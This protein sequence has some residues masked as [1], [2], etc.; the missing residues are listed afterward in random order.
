MSPIGSPS[1]DRHP[2]LSRLTRCSALALGL[3]ETTGVEVQGA[4]DLLRDQ[5]TNTSAA[6]VP[7]RGPVAERA[8]DTAEIKGGKGSVFYRAHSYHTKVPVEGL[9]RLIEH[10]TDPG[11]V[12]VDPFAGSGMT[13][14]AALLTARRAILSDLSP[15]AVH[16]SRGYTT[17]VDP[18]LVSNAAEKIL[19]TLL[20]VENTLYGDPRGRL[21]Y[22]VWSDV[23]VCP[24]CGTDIVFWDAGVDHES[25]QVKRDLACHAGHGPYPKTRLV[26]RRAIPVQENLSTGARKRLVREVG[27]PAR[28]AAKIGRADIPWWYPTTPW[29]S[30]R[31][32]WRGQHRDMAISTAADF[33]T[34]RNL[35]GL[36]ALWNEI[37]QLEEA[38]IRDALRF[39]FTATVNRASRRYQWHPTRPTNVL[40]ST[41]Y[42]ASL[43]YEFNVFSLFRRK[44][45]T[46]IEMFER[47][48]RATGACE[49]REGSATSLDWLPDESVDYVFTDPPFGSNIFYADSSFLWEAWLGKETD[50]SAE[51]VVNKSVSA[52]HGGKSLPDYEALM[53]TA[54]SEIARVLRPNAWASLQFHNSDD[55]VWSSIQR[56]VE[57][58]GF[59][60]EA[61]VIMDKNQASFKGLRHERYGE[62]V[63]NFDL[64]MHLRRSGPC[65]TAVVRAVVSR[66]QLVAELERHLAT[67]P[68]SRRTTPFLHSVAMR[69]L[70]SVGGDLRGW[71]FAAIE[72]LCASTFDRSGV[73][74]T[75]K[76]KDP[77]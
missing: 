59:Q 70:L 64:V 24:D 33:F 35:Y 28:V 16:I 15:A 38:C 29:E 76:M 4:F 36:S 41:M 62:K 19:H 23:F 66:E 30:H 58:A 65:S 6:L 21:E 18:V 14:L 7:H 73:A 32:M 12:V 55:A 9:T 54:M 27:E 34:D 5:P 71:R 3:D 50:R 13:G 53:T 1:A 42:M 52:V 31:E 48:S 20:E 37:S 47:T 72:D 67:A 56:S 11:D 63:A 26:W 75:L 8:V 57:A 44:L 40:S 43:N 49:V 74:W 25:G 51:A 69:Y 68:P 17:Q 46:V 22:T 61:A 2:G 45:A 10:F 60:V 39:V 77:V